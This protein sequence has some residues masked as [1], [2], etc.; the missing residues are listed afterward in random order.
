MICAQRRLYMRRYAQRRPDHLA[1][2]DLGYVLQLRNSEN[3]RFESGD[4]RRIAAVAETSTSATLSLL[5]MQRE[6]DTPPCTAAQFHLPR[7]GN[8]N[9]IFITRSQRFQHA[10]R[11]FWLGSEAGV[12]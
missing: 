8:P 5:A 10:T 7:R 2:C 3:R 4:P 1:I 11:D 6:H 12:P 9:K